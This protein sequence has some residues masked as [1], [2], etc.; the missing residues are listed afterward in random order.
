MKPQ[1]S[2]ILFEASGKWQ[3]KRSD[4]PK[5][6]KALGLIKLARRQRVTVLDEDGRERFKKLEEEQLALLRKL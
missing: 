5:V 3:P 4:V 1:D 6:N 2:K